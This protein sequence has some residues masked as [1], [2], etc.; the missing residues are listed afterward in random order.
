MRKFSIY[1]I[2]TAI[3]MQAA[4]ILAQSP[5]NPEPPITLTI[6]EWH[7]ELGPTFDRVSLIVTNT[8]KEVFFEP[9]C[10]DMR[11]VYHVSVSYNGVLLEEKD[12]AARHR[13]EA[14][15][16][17]NCTRELGVN[18]IKPGESFRRWFDLADRY[19]LSKPGTYEVT[20]SRETDPDHSEMSV[21]VKSNTLT[22]I[23]PEPEAD[24]PQ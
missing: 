1:S 23:V 19:D 14:E 3:A 20:V 4:V 16:A 6:S 21:T 15:Q 24:A 22:V 8:S 5:Q 9:G 2:V 12:A 7:H 10:S 11:D 17:A 18:P 13:G